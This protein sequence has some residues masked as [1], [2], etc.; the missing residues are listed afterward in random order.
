M[1]SKSIYF[2]RKLNVKLPTKHDCDFSFSFTEKNEETEI[3]V[4]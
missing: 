3:S 2:L 4:E 1:L